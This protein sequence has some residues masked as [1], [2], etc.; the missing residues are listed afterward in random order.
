MPTFQIEQDGR[1]FKVQAGSIADATEALKSHLESSKPAPGMIE[2]VTRAAARGIPIVGGMLNKANAATNAALAPVI[3]PLLPDSMEKLPEKSFGERYQH[4]LDI[5]EGKDK[6]FAQEHPV[7][8]TAAEIAGGVASTGVAAA[9]ATGAK[10]LGLTGRTMPQLM[11]RGAASNAAI[12]GADAAVR[13]DN[14]LTAAAVGAGIGGV[15]PGVGRLINSKVVEPI[16]NLVRGF[17]DPAAEAERRVASALDRDIRNGDRGL[18]L[19]EMQDARATNQ[20]AALI[21]TGGEVTRAM[22]RSAAN[23]SPEARSTLNHLIDN[24]FES[25]AP[26]LAEWLQQSFHYPDATA[27]REAIDSIARTVNRATYARAHS[28]PAAQ[29]MWDE[30]FEQLMQAPVV[31]EAARGATMTGANR[32]AAQ[33]FTP[34]RRP[35]EFHDQESLTPRYTRRADDQGREILPNLEF[36]DHVKRNLDDKINTLQRSGQNSAARDAQELRARLVE[37]LDRSVPEYAAARRGAAAFFGADDAIEAGQN[38]VGASRQ[39]RTPD[40][41]RQLAQMSPVERQLFQ[42]GYVSRLVQTIEQSGDR[43]TILNKISNSPGA[44]EEMEVAL[45]PQRARE[46]E[47]R[48]R[49]EGLMDVARNTVQGNS[50]TARQLVELGLAGGVGGYESYQGDPQ[51]LIKAALV[52]GAARGHRVVDERVAREVARLLASDNV[53]QVQRGLRIL[54]RNQNMMRSIRNADAAIASVSARGAEPGVTDFVSGQ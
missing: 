27:Q 40:V 30:G 44:R 41:R 37:K 46:V 26:R 45:G 3:D 13:G 21:D 35:F 22:A 6:G 23:T 42:D 25:Q 7:A 2:G 1:R 43:R 50:T 54:T 36:W 47:A 9:T 8:D 5:Q 18:T 32:S 33:G 39:F 34:V 29:S 12:S 20:P 31:Q 11:A 52:Y 16:R 24:R 14:P 19:Q 10:L 17:S 28:R 15:A 51:A 38:Y 53:G 49:V 4:A 48:L